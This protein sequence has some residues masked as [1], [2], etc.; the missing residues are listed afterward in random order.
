MFD[1]YKDWSQMC[2]RHQDELAELKPE[3]YLTN[4]ISIASGGISSAASIDVTEYN[5]FW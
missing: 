3:L 5:T 4:V 1:S 2:A